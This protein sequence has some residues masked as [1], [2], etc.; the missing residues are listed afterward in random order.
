MFLRL[1]GVHIHRVSLTHARRIYKSGRRLRRTE[2]EAWTSLVTRPR[3]R[4]KRGLISIVG[5]PTE[6]S[7]VLRFQICCARTKYLS[8]IYRNRTI[9]V[10]ATKPNSS[11]TWKGLRWQQNSL[12]RD[13]RKHKPGLQSGP[14]LLLVSGLGFSLGQSCFAYLCQSTGKRSIR[15][16]VMFW[17]KRGQS[18]VSSPDPTLSRGETVWWTKSNF[19]G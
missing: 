5:L 17:E 2:L 13:Q 4:R 11:W 6:K 18:L 8:E 3:G 10:G 12:G 19:L 7:K 15:D 1:L 14:V 9:I 16:Y